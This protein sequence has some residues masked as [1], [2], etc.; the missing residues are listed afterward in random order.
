[1]LK[2]NFEHDSSSVSNRLNIFE[3]KY[4]H[5]GVCSVN[6]V[7]FFGQKYSKDPINKTFRSQM[8]VISMQINL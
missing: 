6:V 4:S 2:I 3:S 8:S 7:V 5:G 1:M